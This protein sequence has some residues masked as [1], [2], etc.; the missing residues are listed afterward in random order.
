MS[1]VIP[2][3]TNRKMRDYSL[4]FIRKAFDNTAEGQDFPNG[5]TKEEFSYHL[6]IQPLVWWLLFP[7]SDWGSGST[8]DVLCP[9]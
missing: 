3:I 7:V 9:V 5:L 1:Y 2:M 4:R 8:S 6:I